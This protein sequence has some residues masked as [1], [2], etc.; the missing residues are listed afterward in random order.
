MLPD[1]TNSHDA[2]YNALYLQPC[3]SLKK[4]LMACLHQGKGKRRPRR[5]DKNRRQQILGL[6]SIHL[7]PPGIE[8]RLIR[9]Y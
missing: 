4:E 7:R 6:V 8:D 1:D 9:D 3:G 5:R 2:I